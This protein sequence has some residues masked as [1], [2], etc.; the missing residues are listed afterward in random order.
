MFPFLKRVILV[1]LCVLA[2]ATALGA[3]A[4]GE[5]FTLRS[6][7][8]V[9]SHG[10]SSSDWDSR[11]TDPGAVFYHDGKFH[12][13]RN[14]FKDW[15]DTVQIGYLTSEDGI[16]WTEATEDPV[17]RTANVS[18]AE[19]AAL[20]TSALV[21]DDGTWVLYFYTWNRG[22]TSESVIGRATAKAP[23]GPWTVD[24]KPV[25]TGGSKGSWD[26]DGIASASVTRTDMGYMMFYGGAE[27]ATG[28]AI[29]MA[30]SS[31]GIVWTKHNDPA[32]TDALYAE[33]DPVFEAPNETVEFHQPRVE[34]TEAGYVMI[35]RQ[36]PTA[37]PGN[38]GLGIA[39][40]KDGMAWQV[41]TETPFWKRNTIP[42]SSGFWWTA[43]AYHDKT[44]Y[45]YIEGGR[46]RV[47]DIFVATSTETFFK[48]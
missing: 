30:T 38:M 37:N 48:N 11:Y 29:G 20:A 35:F 8:P 12:M 39:T 17:L 33:S 16:T 6:D 31:D 13:F 43:T 45:L 25:L 47:T 3:R 42:G 9:V 40:S 26:H 36:F 27:Q 44:L 21:Q 23:L 1:V 14:G 10:K 4:Q 19:I 15:P 32:T 18:F 7:S 2:G 34:K 28:N 41:V 24:E 5:P 46:G 22:A